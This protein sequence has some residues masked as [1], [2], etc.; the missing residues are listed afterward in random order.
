MAMK[1]TLTVLVPVYNEE[2][3]VAQSLRRLKILGKSPLLKWVQVI[4][5]DDASSDSSPQVLQRF[6]KA[7]GRGGRMRWEFH[8]H[9]GN[10]G[11]GAAIRTALARAEGEI[12]VVHDADLEYHP[13]DIL[14]MLKPFLEDNAE[15]VYG[16]RFQAREYRRVLFFRHELGNKLLTFLSNLFSNLNLTDMETCYKAIKTPLFKSIPLGSCIRKLLL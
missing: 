7:E 4:V 8:R 12:T 13:E 11:K 16:S 15:A 1:T 2:T 6:A 14:L 10:Q 3:L 9:P 5:V